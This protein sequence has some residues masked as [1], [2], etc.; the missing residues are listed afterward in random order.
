MNQKNFRINYIL[1][2]ILCILVV[3]TNSLYFLK[4]RYNYSG[5]LFERLGSLIFNLQEGFNIISG[6]NALY[7]P[8]LLSILSKLTGLNL[9]E[10]IYI[11]II[12]IS[13]FSIRLFSKIF[14]EE[15]KPILGMSIVIYLMFFSSIAHYDE[16]VIACILYPYFIYCYFK[17]AIVQRN[18][19]EYS[20]LLILFFLSV[21]FF[22]PP[23]EIWAICFCFTFTLLSY[24]LNI[25][26]KDSPKYSL[27]KSHFNLL[28]LFVVIWFAYNP[29]FYDQL[30]Y[31]SPTLFSDTLIS[32]FSSLFK[33]SLHST[34]D[35]EYIRHST[36]K[37]SL[38]IN[39]SY[40]SLSIF[41]ILFIFIYSFK[42]RDP[43]FWTKNT[44]NIFVISLIMPFF[45]D[46]ILYTSLGLFT[47]RYMYLIYP[48]ISVY[49][50]K[51]YSKKMFNVILCLFITLGC[52]Q[53]ASSITSPNKNS[54]PSQNEAESLVTYFTTKT[55]A[56]VH[57][58]TDH[59]N[60]GCLRAFFA[61]MCGNPQ[62]FVFE[63][64]NNEKYKQI[65][66]IEN[67]KEMEFNYL[68]IDINNIN[69]PILQGPP[70]WTYLKPLSEYIH[71][72]DNNHK[73]LKVYNTEHFVIYSS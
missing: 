48:H 47:T 66:G 13:Y 49:F 27:N 22:G 12:M 35:F 23:M 55:P 58:M 10:V 50:S 34:G 26:S 64:Y 24:L 63:S 65:L 60:Y 1:F 4:N 40:I 51:F 62:Y 3:L 44:K 41:P 2:K 17:Y 38:F 25:N 73:L 8:S 67:L 20:I 19:C 18:K 56:Q 59:Y 15:E 37:L 5:F 54:L 32:F 14:F 7:S 46:F 61:E 16:Y 72:V 28:I 30:L 45:E 6:F 57:I 70:S 52:C 33:D 69:K 53:Y 42:K 11:P 36:S 21:K 43:F 71:M 31:R 9:I 29:K 39:I 68:I